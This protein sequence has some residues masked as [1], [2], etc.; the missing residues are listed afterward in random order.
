MTGKCW[1]NPV[2]KDLNCLVKVELNLLLTQMKN[3][4]YEIKVLSF[5][6]RTD[7]IK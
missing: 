7:S 1:K 4:I 2:M 3:L 6:L 5:Y